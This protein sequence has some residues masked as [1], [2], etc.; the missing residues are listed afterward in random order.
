MF[1]RYTEHALRALA[2]SRSAVSTFGDPPLRPSHILVGI[3][4]DRS[5]FN[6]DLTSALTTSIDQLRAAV[7]R[8]MVFVENVPSD[9]LIPMPVGN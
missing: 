2:L 4:N 7:E 6:R 9:E 1:E 8:E 3:I 5:A